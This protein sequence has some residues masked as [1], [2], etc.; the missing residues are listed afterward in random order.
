MSINNQPFSSTHAKLTLVTLVVG[1]TPFAIPDWFGFNL[2][3]LKNSV[4]NSGIY[5][6][7]LEADRGQIDDCC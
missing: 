6:L 7:P 1:F 5:F 2:P 4:T 3:I